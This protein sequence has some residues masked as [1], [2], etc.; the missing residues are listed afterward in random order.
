[1]HNRRRQEMADHRQVVAAYDRKV[2]LLERALAQLRA[3]LH[4]VLRALVAGD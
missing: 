4:A 1:M 3:E 2:L